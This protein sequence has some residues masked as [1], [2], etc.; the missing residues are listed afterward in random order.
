MQHV[1]IKIGCVDV[2]GDQ[3][4]IGA[5]RDRGEGAD[6]GAGGSAARCGSAATA[7]AQPANA[8][9]KANAQI[10]PPRRSR[11]TKN[12][13]RTPPPPLGALGMDVQPAVRSKKEA[14]G[15]SVRAPQYW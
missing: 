4:G 14:P 11:R 15:Q 1:M 12:H 2:Q 10:P 6:G 9:A 3:P 13:P 8:K 7:A 5:I